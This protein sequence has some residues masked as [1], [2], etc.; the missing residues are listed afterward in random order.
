MHRFGSLSVCALLALLPGCASFSG[1]SAPQQPGLAI[2]TEWSAPTAALTPDATPYWTLLGDP[3]LDHFVEQ[4][5]SSNR[6]LAQAASRIALARA[7]VRASRAN[8]LPQVSAD[9]R[10][11]RDVGTRANTDPQFSIGGDAQWEIDL[12]GRISRDVAASRADLLAAGFGLADLQRLIV[13]QVAQTTVSARVLATQLAIARDTLANQDENLQI[14]EWRLQAGLVSS[15]DVEQARAQRA[16]T[17]ASIPALERDL[18]QAA[19]AISTLIGE[20]P[21]PVRG[22]LETA[23]TGIPAPPEAAGFQAPAE[24][25]RRRPDVRQA[26]AVL[27]AD[28]A[29]IDVA[30]AQL[31]PLVR[32]TGNIGTASFGLDGLFDLI[33]GGLFAGVNQLIFDGGRT[34][35]QIDSAEA[36]AQGSLAA[37]EQTIL[38]A[39]ADV[40]NGD[41]ALRK[42][43]ERVDALTIARGAASAAAILARSQYQAGLI[44]FQTLLTAESQLLAARNAQAAAEA[45]RANAFIALQQALGA[46]AE[47]AGPPPPIAAPNRDEPN[48]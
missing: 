15:L 39:L 3:Q 12:F 24:V 42:A 23:S 6:D 1:A 16:Q 43:R 37:W 31:L 46:G 27:L 38:T 34:R 47:V 14:A 48:S 32:L 13:G 40:E 9:A 18:A 28:T 2:P 10:L 33:T 22:A 7:A 4:A 17:A 20:A 19:N 5:I 45:E 41:V 44:D 25:L 35:A 21:G 36:R 30:R 11:R 29:R 26:E 8:F